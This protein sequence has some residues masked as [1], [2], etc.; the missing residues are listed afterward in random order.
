MVYLE[1]HQNFLTGLK[2]ID[3]QHKRIFNY[4]NS[5]FELNKFNKSIGSSDIR[6]RLEDLLNYIYSHF[7][8]EEDL[9]REKGID[10]F[11][12]HINEHQRFKDSI[13][14]IMKTHA[15]SEYSL[16]FEICK[17]IK[18]FYTDHILFYDKILVKDI[19]EK[20]V[21]LEEG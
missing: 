7:R 20:K 14:E 19:T 13:Q 4:L 18:N 8:Y 21:D 9:M 10:N 6:K 15:E 17:F 5:L 11:L 12:A 2:D 3:L 16:V 1:F